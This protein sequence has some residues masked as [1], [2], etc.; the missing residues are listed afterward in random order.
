MCSQPTEQGI[1]L[2]RIS[3]SSNSKGPTTDG[4]SSISGSN[5]KTQTSTT[6]CPNLNINR[7]TT[8]TDRLS[9]SRGPV[10]PAS[11]C[12]PLYALVYSLNTTGPTTQNPR[13]NK[14][15]G[16]Q[17]VKYNKPPMTQSLITMSTSNPNAKQL[18]KAHTRS[19]PQGLEALK[20]VPIGCCSFQFS[21]CM[22]AHTQK[23]T[24]TLQKVR[25]PSIDTFRV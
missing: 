3:T 5:T 18:F 11:H 4:R 24:M 20:V 15:L 12:M 19:E 2:T 25:N 9:C 1:F 14:P 6:L 22:H 16:S 7:N 13:P 21:S 23:A 8:S 17:Q 10:A